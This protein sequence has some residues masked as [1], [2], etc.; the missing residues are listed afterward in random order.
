VTQVR[1][2]LPSQALRSSQREF[3]LSRGKGTGTGQTDFVD[4]SC[5]VPVSVSVADHRHLVSLGVSFRI[6]SSPASGRLPEQGPVAQ[7]TGAALN[8]PESPLDLP[9]IAPCTHR[10]LS[11]SNKFIRWFRLR[12]RQGRKGS[13]RQGDLMEPARLYPGPLPTAPA[14]APGMLEGL[15]LLLRARA[16]AEEFQTSL[17]D[18]GVE[19]EA[20]R[21]LGLAE[22]DFRWLVRK[23]LVESARE[24][25]P[26]G[27]SGRSFVPAPALTFSGRTYFILTPAGSH[28]ARQVTIPSEAA[29]APSCTALPGSGVRPCWD[30]LRRELHVAHVVVKQFRQPAPAQ[31]LILLS[32]EELGWPSRIDDPLPPQ[33]GMDPKQRL[34]Q[35][36]SNLNRHQKCPLLRFVGDG[37]GR[38]LGWEWLAEADAA[39]RQGSATATPRPSG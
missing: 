31:E 12:E 21:R 19:V 34:H 3:V 2:D 16:Y 28:F 36:V 20:L 17:W 13:Q 11:S 8:F 14:L 25:T 23:G 35:T 26:S 10:G 29:D 24:T 38:G 33:Q 22:P 32:F 9:V 27:R 7:S 6:P 4:A 30:R 15:A 37:H 5:P 1:D 39:L 18:F